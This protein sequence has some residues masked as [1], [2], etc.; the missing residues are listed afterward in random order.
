MKLTP[1]DIRHKEFRR[2]MRGYSEE[3]VDIFLDEVADE[4]ERLFQANIE[5]QDHVTRLDDQVA[6]FDNLK[7]TLQKTLVS[8]Q[9]QADEMRANA[10]KEAELTLRDSELKA[11]DIIADSYAEKQR[12]Q[13]S[14]LQLRQVEEDF[15]FKFR[16][17]LQA[18]LNLLKEDEESEDRAAFG[19]VVSGVE[20]ELVDDTAQAV[21]VDRPATGRQA[22]QGSDTQRLDH[23]AGDSAAEG[24]WRA[25]GESGAPVSTP[26]GQAPSDPAV[27]EAR[28]GIPPQAPVFPRADAADEPVEE[29]TA[30]TP[31]LDDEALENEFLGF[32]PEAPP[33]DG[34]ARFA[35]GRGAEIPPSED[36]FLAKWSERV[37]DMDRRDLD[38]HDAGALTELD[39]PR[40]PGSGGIRPLAPD[41]EPKKRESSVRRFLFGGKG[42]E[43]E[44]RSEEENDR[45]FKW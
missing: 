2:A 3:E 18:H 43:E 28:S 32:R 26:A 41:Y 27:V 29:V 23:E 25:D 31:G 37:G 6:Q 20:R 21:E 10:R 4:F 5:L 9:Q 38:R 22:E 40:E 17:L 11:R 35:G 16:S 45:D 34:S 15:R 39:E 19:H 13:Q 12:V 36:D 14:L 44:E 42:D 33:A 1:I 8:A 24:R 7:E 30:E